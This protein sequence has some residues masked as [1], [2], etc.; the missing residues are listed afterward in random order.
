M[1]DAMPGILAAFPETHLMIV[2]SGS[3][4][5][6][7]R[8]RANSLGLD[9]KIHLTG[10]QPDPGPYFG[11]MDIF[12]LSSVFEG[13][14]IAVL[15]AMAA[16]LPVLST[17]AGGVAEVVHHGRHGVIV[18]ERTPEC[19][20]NGVVDL[21]KRPEAVRAYGLAARSYYREHLR[22]ACMVREY[23]RVYRECLSRQGLEV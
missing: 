11:A 20:A 4:E 14:P 22:V 2:G 15:Q 21:L 23:D 18:P 8:E 1:I 7:L 13:L 9:G 19:F 3:L 12:V 5:Q 16:G 10:W 6:A 17:E